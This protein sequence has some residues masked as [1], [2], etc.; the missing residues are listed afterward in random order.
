MKWEYLEKWN[1]STDQLSYLGSER[2][3]LVAVVITSANDY[4]YVFKRLV[5]VQEP[6]TLKEP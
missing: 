4:Y 5:V 6:H 1:L 3:E 2:W